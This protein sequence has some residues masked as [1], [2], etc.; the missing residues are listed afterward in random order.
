MLVGG[1]ESGGDEVMVVILVERR[2]N[3][4]GC[5]GVVVVVGGVRDGGEE[6]TLVIAGVIA[7]AILE[8]VMAGYGQRRWCFC[9]GDEGDG[10]W[11]W[12]YLEEVGG[13]DV[14][15]VGGSKGGYGGDLGGE[16]V[17]DGCGRWI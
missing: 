1:E 2:R 13:D 16:E 10:E 17:E 7:G 8:V 9:G 5:D 4:G 15:V 11:R 6:I 3:K 12:V 14:V